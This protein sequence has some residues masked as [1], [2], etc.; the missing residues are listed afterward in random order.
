MSTRTLP[1]LARA[2]EREHQA[3]QEAARLAAKHAGGRPHPGRGQGGDV[4]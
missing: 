2:L 1:D 3:G 4:G